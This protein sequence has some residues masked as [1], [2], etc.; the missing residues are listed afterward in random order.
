M[1]RVHHLD[2]YLIL[3]IFQGTSNLHLVGSCP[4]N[5]AI[6]AIN[7][8]VGNILHVGERQ[9]DTTL[10][11]FVLLQFPR[12]RIARVTT[13]IANPVVLMLAPV[14]ELPALDGQACLAEV[15]SP[16]LAIYSQRGN[17]LFPAWE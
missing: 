16:R 8:D 1:P 11:D 17:V 12:C 5:A 13:E 15:D 6:L 3:A 2:F 9:P 7:P 4:G 14:E 10:R